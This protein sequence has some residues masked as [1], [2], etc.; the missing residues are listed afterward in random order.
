MV[1]K[2]KR[3]EMH[4]FEKLGVSLELSLK[5][6]AVIYYINNLKCTERERKMILHTNI[7]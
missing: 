3:H 6:W 5:T 1:L 4:S 7:C 2:L